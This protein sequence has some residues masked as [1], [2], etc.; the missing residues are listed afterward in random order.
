MQTRK[1]IAIHEKDNVGMAR[2]KLIDGE[3]VEIE[4]LSP[5]AYVVA[6][7]AI[8]F[9]FK[10]ALADIKKGEGVIKYGEKIGMASVNIAKGQLVH[11]HN[12]EGFR[13]RGDQKT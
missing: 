3:T 12:I 7:E 5:G 9:G 1:I 8:P 6:A 4:G 10:I 2:K 13:G 11:V